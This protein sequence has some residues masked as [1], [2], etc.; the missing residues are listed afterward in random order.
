MLRPGK[1]WMAPASLRTRS[2]RTRGRGGGDVDALV[3]HEAAMGSQEPGRADAQGEIRIRA[4]GGEMHFRRGAQADLPAIEHHDIVHQGVVRGHAVHAG[5]AV[6]MFARH[7]QG[8][9]GHAEQIADVEFQG[10]AHVQGRIEAR[11]AGWIVIDAAVVVGKGHEGIAHSQGAAAQVL[12]SAHA[13][14]RRR[15]GEGGKGH[16]AQHHLNS[17]S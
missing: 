15:D 5:E 17:P 14:S 6:G 16:Q 8:V 13:P 3:Q 7:V 11:Q 12:R 10:H 2:V 9:A 1:G 4:A